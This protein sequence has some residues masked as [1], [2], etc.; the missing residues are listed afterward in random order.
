MLRLMAVRLRTVAAA[1]LVVGA[2][3]GCAAQGSGAAP[4][5]D[6]GPMTAEDYVGVWTR[7]DGEP[8]EQGQGQ[9]ATF[10]MASRPMPAHCEWEK[11]VVLQVPWPLGSTYAIG[12]NVAIRHYTRD[13]DGV[14]KGFTGHFR[15]D[16]DL[17]AALPAGSQPTGYRLGA[18]ELWFGPDKGEDYAY[19]VNPDGVEQWPVEVKPILCA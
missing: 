8:A 4:L 15:G 18:V 14:L 6:R 13:A 17:D 7:P 1:A 16:L 2:C 10:E 9:A 3:V 12:S 19:L 5:A 11:A